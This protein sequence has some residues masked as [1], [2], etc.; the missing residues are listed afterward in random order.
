MK[1]KILFI[2]ILFAGISFNGCSGS[3]MPP[4]VCEI[5]SLVCNASTS[6]CETIP[7]IPAEVCTY[8]N[9]ACLNLEILCSTEPGTAGHDQARES[10]K[11]IN[12]N[13]SRIIKEYK[14]S[15]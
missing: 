5:G 9:L 12:I 6:L 8:V 3:Q 2:L 14:D 7:Q 11:E 10:L 13:L 1:K 15:R 4:E